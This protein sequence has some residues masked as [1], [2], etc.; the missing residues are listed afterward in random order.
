M[1]TRLPTP[2]PTPETFACVS[3]PLPTYP[4]DA[5]RS[6]LTGHVQL[7]IDVSPD[8]WVTGVSVTGS[9]GASDLDDRAAATVNNWQFT[10]TRTGR[11]GV[12]VSVEFQLQ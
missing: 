10:Q 1:T 9:S 11:S 6:S 2:V 5:K 12:P 3:C 8:G 4:S 7:V